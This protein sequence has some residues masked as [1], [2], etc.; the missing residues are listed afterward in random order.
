MDGWE[1]CSRIRETS[2]V[3]I[4]MLTTRNNEKDKVRGLDLGADDYVTKPFGLKEL[5]ARIRALLRRCHRAPGAGAR[6][7]TAWAHSRAARTRL[8]RGQRGQDHPS[9]L[10]A[11][12]KT[13][14]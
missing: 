6:D 9:E 4:I 5:K 10:A 14:K 12:L 7:Q 1:A 3:P 11:H 13:W 2:D 8:W